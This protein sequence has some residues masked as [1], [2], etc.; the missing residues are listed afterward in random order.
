MGVDVYFSAW[1]V[2]GSLKS[3]RSASQ[4]DYNSKL[5]TEL[6]FRQDTRK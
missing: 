6:I 5:F 2:G 3:F 4:D 1:Q